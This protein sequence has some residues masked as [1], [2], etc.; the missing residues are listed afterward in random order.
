M[1]R[2]EAVELFPAA[3]LH[4][5]VVDLLRNTKQLRNQYVADLTLGYPMCLSACAGELLYA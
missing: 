3:W 1:G 4:K 2:L 5:R